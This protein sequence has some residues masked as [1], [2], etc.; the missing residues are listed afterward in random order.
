MNTNKMKNDRWVYLFLTAI[1]ILVPAVVGILLFRGRPATPGIGWVSLLPHLHAAL[2]SVTVVML[3]TGFIL[4]RNDQKEWH[5]RVMTM[6]VIMGIIFL[7]SYITYHYLTASTVFGDANHDGI[8]ELSEADAVGKSRNVYLLLL[9]S[10]IVLAAM[11]VPFVLFA[12]Y[13]AL[14]GN[15]NRHKKIVKFALPVWLYVSL[16]GVIVYW[17]IR[18]YY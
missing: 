2:N 15:F 4:I 3:I 17:M 9:I 16:T 8:L 1:S 10:H 13:Y 12:F 11:V 6:S 5:H 14:T 18:P 7:V